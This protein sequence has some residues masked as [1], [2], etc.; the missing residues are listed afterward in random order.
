[1]RARRSSE[2]DFPAP[3]GAAPGRGAAPAQALQE[4]ARPGG[5]AP[6]QRQQLADAAA[7]GGGG[8]GFGAQE[9]ARAPARAGPPADTWDGPVADA[10]PFGVS[11]EA[12]AREQELQDALLAAN[13]ERTRAEGAMTRLLSRGAL[14]TAGERR[15]KEALERDMEAAERRIASL[16]RQVRAA[17]GA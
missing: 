9:P 5:A 15:Q 7:G 1:V 16:R 2:V 6:A 14:R 11:G 12:R 3:R 13:Q 4:D 17:S 10:C 8:G